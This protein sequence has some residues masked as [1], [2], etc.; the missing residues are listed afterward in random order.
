MVQEGYGP[1][2][3][4]PVGQGSTIQFLQYQSKL[5]R[6]ADK[7]VCLK[8]CTVLFLVE[9]LRESDSAPLDKVGWR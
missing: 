3:R 1:T 7:I 2:P 8:I 5:Q 9:N 6:N 4:L